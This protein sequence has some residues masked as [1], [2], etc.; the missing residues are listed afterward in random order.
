MFEF[1]RRRKPAGV[2]DGPFRVLGDHTKTEAGYET[3]LCKEAVARAAIEGRA[4]NFLDVG[5]GDGN[6]A[7]LLGIRENLDYDAAMHAAN[8]A[9]FDERFVYH[10]LDL[11]AKTPGTIVADLC[12][13]DF[14]AQ[15]AQWQG[16]F[17]VVYSNNVFEHL[18]RPWLAA[19]HILWL[20][21]PGAVCVVI[22]PFALRY[23]AVPE[24]YFR[25]TH[26]GLVALFEDAGAVRVVVSGYDIKG[27][28]NN[29]QG[30]GRHN[31]IVP[32]DACGAWREN[33]FVVTVVEKV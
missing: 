9:R 15:M 20:M 22:A 33:W 27:R 16:F 23:H 29:W 8:R 31:D 18:R 2:A 12:A 10:C 25:Y 3:G 5:G 17:D 32:I 28:R 6:L 11:E 21:K 7:Y 26:R 4:G 14:R 1:L 13:R 24:D 19:E 30:M